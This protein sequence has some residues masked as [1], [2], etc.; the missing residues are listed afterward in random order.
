MS[1]TRS[2][3]RPPPP[4]AG[5]AADEAKAEAEAWMGGLESPGS[6]GGGGGGRV[7]AGRAGDYERRNSLGQNE[8]ATLRKI[9]AQ[10]EVREWRPAE[11]I[12]R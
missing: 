11:V 3:G 4:H 6:G 2:R 8:N 10:M 1:P 9:E 12:M 5:G 7:G